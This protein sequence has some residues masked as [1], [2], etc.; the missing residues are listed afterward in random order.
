MPWTEK[1]RPSNLCNVVSQDD[2]IKIFRNA[3]V[4]YN[5][6][7]LLLYGPSG[8]GK[9]TSILA[10]ANMLFGPDKIKERVMELNA[11]D[12]R[13]INVVRTKIM[14]F[15]K[16]S[17]GNPDKKYP[18]PPYK[19]IILDEAD[20]MTK[21]AQSAMKK[22]IETYSKI[23]RFC[24][25][26][27]YITKIIDPIQSRCSKLRF[28]SIHPKMITERLF[29][30]S[31]LEKLNVSENVLSLIAHKSNGDMRKAITFLQN[32]S[33]INSIDNTI[34]EIDLHNI[35][36]GMD[37]IVIE[38]LISLCLNDD[39]NLKK[40]L[41]FVNGIWKQGYL[42]ND[43]L[44]EVIYLICNSKC[45][46][47]RQKEEIAFHISAI[48]RHLINGADEF[49]QLCDLF[50]FIKAIFKNINIDKTIDIL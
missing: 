15:A 42:L 22:I 33:Y 16:E 27:N 30:I 38:N 7:H 26:C 8:T 5:L 9:T 49:I 28:K 18:S 46:N 14:N 39:N 40:I 50:C 13:G 17:I 44:E 1:Y 41:W 19:I 3:L 11:S 37:K 6:P 24:L 25:I 29:C 43:I 36:N 31:K 32:L 10:I 34:K 48:D 23:T 2:T 4:E 20:A 12:D 47:N 21:E 45:L 35:T